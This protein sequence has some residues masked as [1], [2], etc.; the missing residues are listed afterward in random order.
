MLDEHSKRILLLRKRILF[1]DELELENIDHAR[2][3]H[4]AEA[5]PSV[6]RNRLADL[7]K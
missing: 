4:M 6:V 1:E 3:M 2:L 7:V 5:F